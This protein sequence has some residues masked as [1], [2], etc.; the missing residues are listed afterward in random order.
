[1]LLALHPLK[2]PPLVQVFQ[3]HCSELGNL[4]VSGGCPSCLLTSP[5]ARRFSR[6]ALRLWSHRLSS[7]LQMP[8]LHQDP[9]LNS[10]GNRTTCNTLDGL[11]TVAI[12]RARPATSVCITQ[13]ESHMRYVLTM[14]L[15]NTYYQAGQQWACCSTTRAGCANMP[16][17]CVNGNMI[18][19]VTATGGSSLT[20]SL[21]TRAW[22]VETTDNVIIELQLTSCSTQLWTA[23]SDRSFTVCNTAFMY[24]NDRD[25]NP[26]ANI[27]CGVSSLN[28]SYYR[29]Q[30][31][32]TS[33]AS[34]IVSLAI[35]ALV[36]DI[37][38]RVE[39]R[40]TIP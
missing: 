14:S 38:S 1:V 37:N 19:S 8:S 29:Q 31:V 3:R 27:I 2:I 22:Y 13:S 28:W 7:R 33:S 25:S 6:P 15:G 12:G 35:D 21:V 24:E 30:P 9:T 32:T 17:G 40:N 23:S 18:Y 10:L 20:N 11:S 34:T 5:S 36:A 26:K 39:S 16:I 4:R